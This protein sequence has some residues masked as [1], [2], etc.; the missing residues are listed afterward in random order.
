MKK[1]ATNNKSIPQSEGEGSLL[2][3][4]IKVRMILKSSSPEENVKLKKLDVPV[5][6]HSHTSITIKK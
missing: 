1:L 3:P 2:Q 4:K 5:D 6:T